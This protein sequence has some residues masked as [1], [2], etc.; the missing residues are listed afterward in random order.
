[1][2]PR[3]Q[4]VIEPY[5]TLL[6]L[7]DEVRL[8]E[9]NE[10]ILSPPARRKP[11]KT[12]SD[13]LAALPYTTD[14]KYLSRQIVLVGYGRVGRRIAHYLLERGIPY[15]VVEEG[16]ELV[17]KLR[18]DGIP[19]VVGDESDPI[20]LAQAH[21]ARAAML[22]IATPDTMKVRQM[23]ETARK[24]NPQVEVLI[25]SHSE[26][27]SRLLEQEEAGKIFLGEEELARSIRHALDRLRQDA[28]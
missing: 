16:R 10:A 6:L 12:P 23:V 27:E 13:P 26:V 15:V 7:G 24:I 18:E 21:I 28:E 9:A 17:E 25:R 5:D 8:K 3:G 4:T 14:E 22:I 19:A 20:V 1:M 2:V 11:V